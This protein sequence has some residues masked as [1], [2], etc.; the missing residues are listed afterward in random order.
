MHSRSI[1]LALLAAALA[2]PA[3][4]AD[5]NL[6]VRASVNATCVFTETPY[7]LSLPE[8]D[9]SGTTVY[10]VPATVGVRCTNG[11]QVR[12]GVDG[13]SQSPV[14]RYM[15]LNGT[16]YRLPYQLSWA[17]SSTTGSGFGGTPRDITFSMTATLTPAQYQDAAA[18]HYTDVLNVQLMP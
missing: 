15:T 6:Q 2:G 12:L 10:V 16:P 18:G 9:P 8:I 11:A 14:T 5:A 7:A 4:A 13:V 3:A 1:L 17:V